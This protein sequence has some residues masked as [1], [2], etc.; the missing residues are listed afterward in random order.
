MVGLEFNRT[1][2]LVYASGLSLSWNQT[3]WQSHLVGVTMNKSF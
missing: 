1:G 2:K 3:E